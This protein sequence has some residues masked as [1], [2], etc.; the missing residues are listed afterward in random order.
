MQLFGV[1]DHMPSDERVALKCLLV[2]YFVLLLWYIFYVNFGNCYW[3]VRGLFPYCQAS[4]CLM[5]FCTGPDQKVCARL[6]PILSD[7]IF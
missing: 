6:Q 2:E 4:L 3:V 5:Y 7:D 1:Q